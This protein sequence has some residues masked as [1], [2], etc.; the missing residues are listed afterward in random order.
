VVAGALV[1]QLPQRPDKH[2]SIAHLL[3]ASVMDLFIAYP[4]PVLEVA[5]CQR[6]EHLPIGSCAGMHKVVFGDKGSV[7][8]ARIGNNG[9]AI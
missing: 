3:L 4:A 9:C 5:S 1:P 7:R 8:P 6:F 2:P